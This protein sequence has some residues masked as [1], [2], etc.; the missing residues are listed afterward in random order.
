LKK[1]FGSGP[2]LQTDEW[3]P[4]KRHVTE[5]HMF[6]LLKS[7]VFGIFA[8]VYCINPT[9]YPESLGDGPSII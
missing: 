1:N 7:R 6:L 5:A 4:H 3:R 9:F 2:D 8:H